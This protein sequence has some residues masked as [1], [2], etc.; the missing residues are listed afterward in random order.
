MSLQHA[1]NTV[2]SKALGMAES[3]TPILKVKIFGFVVRRIE[4]KKKE[5]YNYVDILTY[6]K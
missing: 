6:E 5:F 2:K 4:K 3:L 1:Y